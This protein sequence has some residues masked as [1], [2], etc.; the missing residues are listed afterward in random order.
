MRRNFKDRLPCSRAK[1][2]LKRGLRNDL[3]Y[4]K[5]QVT[6]NSW[7][8]VWVWG[9][10]SCNLYLYFFSTPRKPRFIRMWHRKLDF[11]RA[12][13]SF[14]V[15]WSHFSIS[16]SLTLSHFLLI[17]HIASINPSSLLS[18]L[19]CSTSFAT[20]QSTRWVWSAYYFKSLL[21]TALSSSAID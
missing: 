6:R 1:I 18:C 14:L 20:S 2:I 13:Y 12:K 7:V 17:A 19:F 11:F 21:S 3:A 15:C 9:N 16:L 5:F 8:W 4:I 10:H